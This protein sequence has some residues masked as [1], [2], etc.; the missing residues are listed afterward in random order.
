M[1]VAVEMPITAAAAAAVTEV[2]FQIIMV[3]ETQALAIMLFGI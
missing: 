1:Q 3:M 2:L